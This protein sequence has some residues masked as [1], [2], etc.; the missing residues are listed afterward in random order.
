MAS[1][2]PVPMMGDLP[3]VALLAADDETLVGAIMAV[4][5]LVVTTGLLV[6]L[7][8]AGFLAVA[9]LPTPAWPLTR[10]VEGRAWWLLRV[11]WWATLVG[12]LAGLLLHGPFTAGLPLSRALDATLLAQTVGTRFGGI[13]AV[14]VLLLLLLVAVL[15]VWVQGVAA[16]RRTSAWV[17]VGV[18]AAALMATPALS[19]HAAAGPDAAVGAVVGV[20]HFSAAAVWFGGLVL[21]G[22]CVLPRAEMGQLQAVPRFSSAAFTAMVVILVTGMVQS[23][24]QVGTLQA[25]GETAYGRLL[26]T[27]VTVFLLLLAVAAR[28][29]VLVRRKLMAQILVGAATS[30]RPA[31]GASGPGL[32]EAADAKS[33]RL[34]R[35]LVLAEVIIALMVLAVTALLGI[36]TPP[37]AA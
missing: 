23:W 11:A 27:K 28:S 21:L 19:G 2:R 24:R 29:R 13:W 17:A 34:L 14:R 9:R 1:V 16:W 20:V 22:T 35:R 32:R 25:L 36:A 30:P 5:R 15:R 12:T 26:L 31:R 33:V 18:L 7:G 4:D 10:R 37:R 8:G 3:V 6:L